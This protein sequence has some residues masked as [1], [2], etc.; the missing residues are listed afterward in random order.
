MSKPQNTTSQSHGDGDVGLGQQPLT[1]P[2]SARFPATDEKKRGEAENRS[3]S[4]L[5][6]DVLPSSR[7]FKEH[8]EKFQDGNSDNDRVGILSPPSE[9]W[10]TLHPPSF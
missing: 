4:C 7:E 8:D 10:V 5:L 2:R 1:P 6:S 9:W 3:D